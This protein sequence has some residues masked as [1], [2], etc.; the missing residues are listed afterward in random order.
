MNVSKQTQLIR[1][2]PHGAYVPGSGIDESQLSQLS[3]T[4]EQI[5][6]EICC[7]AD[8]P[9]IDQQSPELVE[10]LF[11][12][13]FL[14]WPQ[15]ALAD[16][17]ADRQGSQ[18][19][20]IL[21]TTKRMMSL[22]DRVVVLGTG[23]SLAGVRALMDACCQPYFNE[24]TRGQRGSRPRIYFEGMTIDND[25]T[26]GL[27]HLLGADRG[28]QA[29]TVDQSWGLVVIDNPE[30]PA[31]LQVTAQH[32]L[33]ALK[34]HCGGDSSR[35]RERLV[36][37]T[38]EGGTLQQLAQQYECQAIFPVSIGDGDRFS[39]LSEIGLVP[40]ALM[41]INVMKLL[42]G[43]RQV[44]QHFCSAGPGENSVAQL[45][46]VNYLW[47]TKHATAVRVMCIWNNS[48][49]RAGYWV[50]QLLA[51]TL[52]RHTLAATPLTI[53]NTRDLQS[54]HHQHL[55][56]RPDKIIHNLIVESDRFDPLK[57]Q[58]AEPE[59]AS[60]IE[61]GKKTIPEVTA[62]AIVLANQSLTGQNRP[63]TNLRLPRTDEYTMGQ[64]FQMLMLSTVVEARLLGLDPYGQPGAEAYK[65]DMN[66]VLGCL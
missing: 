35:L 23:C 45:A 33:A 36:M 2:E 52:G 1:F 37:V 39:V 43:A 5:R 56:G 17:F 14:S 55:A 54:R 42:E 7:G 51:Q 64:F 11:G 59:R 65:R 58:L 22:V 16:Y 25:A 3:A 41:G 19:A 63:T 13:C 49:E 26:Q 66:R 28:Q 40:G 50:D 12:S 9:S 8:G 4:L 38:R 46:A 27:L 60:R 57:I 6:R 61:P 31:H 29:E 62:E 53:L 10:N 20:R 30:S 47:L 21:S 44:S 48:L 18:L 32:F 15:R 34:V 24:L